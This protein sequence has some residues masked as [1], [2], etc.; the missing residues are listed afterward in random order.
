MAAQSDPR[1][2]STFQGTSKFASAVVILL[3][4]LVLVGWL[5]MQVGAF[6][7]IEGVTVNQSTTAPDFAVD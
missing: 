1:P 3:G 6:K 4:G 5:L 7:D 2:V